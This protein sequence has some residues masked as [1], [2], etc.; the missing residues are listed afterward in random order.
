MSEDMTRRTLLKGTLQSALAA[1]LVGSALMAPFVTEAANAAEPQ[2][3][4]PGSA[5]PE[6]AY[7]PDQYP[8]D[9]QLFT[10][11]GLPGG[12]QLE[13]RMPGFSS[14]DIYV[15][16]ENYDPDDV[17]IARNMKW[18]NPESWYESYLAMAQKNEAIAKTAGTPAEANKFYLRAA[19][20]YQRADVYLPEHDPRMLPTYAKLEEMYNIAWTLVS[21]PFERVQIPYE[22]HMLEGQF[23]SAGAHAPVVVQYG[24]ADSILLSGSSTSGRLWTT[25]GMSFLAFDAPGMG[26]SLRV[27]K[28]YAP[29]DSERVATAAVDYLATRSDVDLDR[30][31]IYGVSLGGSGAPRSCTGEKR[32]KA[33]G[34]WSGAFALQRDI[35]DYYPPIQDR[36]RWLS[37]AKNLKQA[38]AVMARFTLDERVR[39]IEAALLVGYSTDDRI[40]NH[41]GALELYDKAVNARSRE[42]VQGTGHAFSPGAVS[43]DRNTIFANWFAKQL[44]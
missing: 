39:E 38:R 40:M 43:V 26:G 18:F 17:W 23:Y 3:A 7:E 13:I 14:V 37:G 28:L 29:P 35:F 5:N 12:G 21:P 4:E 22:G 27:K 16:P 24:G 19:Q 1:P 25:R 42:T 20:Y 15:H 33:C 2:A 8:P 44:S 31:G 41:Y 36:M 9:Y 34:V 30:L 10:A 32:F 6:A 11:P